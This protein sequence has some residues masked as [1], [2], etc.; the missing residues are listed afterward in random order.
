MEEL[1]NGLVYYKI[2]DKSYKDSSHVYSKKN[3]SI[4]LAEIEKNKKSI[5]NY[6]SAADILILR[7]VHSNKIIDADVESET[8]ESE[9]DGS[10]TS[11]KNLVLAIQ[12][13]DCVPVLLASD[14]GTVIGAAHCG[15]KSAKANIISNLVSSMKE[16][17]AK[18][19]IA[20]IGPAIAQSSYEVDNKYYTD[21]IADSPNNSVFFV[22]SKRE[23]HYMF[24]LPKYVEARLQ[25]AGIENIKNIS[26]DTYT[27][28]LKY[29]SYRRS[30]HSGEPYKE[31]ILS[32][33][34][35]K[36]KL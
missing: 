19:L 14:D 34:I 28:P 25:E 9:A 15:W 36:N 7:Q 8:F 24:D 35:I 3:E 30:Y 33:I 13:A 1:I 11:K 16:K 32:T 23:G 22:E 20:V 27:N 5:I 17:G 10:V 18:N 4:N 2:F 31:N 21:F 6:F 26:E 12:T 29:P